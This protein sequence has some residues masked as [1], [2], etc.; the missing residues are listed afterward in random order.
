M[1]NRVI[2]QQIEKGLLWHA[3]CTF[4]QHVQGRYNIV[5][6]VCKGE[7]LIGKMFERAARFL[8]FS[9]NMKKWRQHGKMDTTLDQNILWLLI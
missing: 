4:I 5:R 6:K 1:V 7:R 2:S 9:G 3:V 8:S